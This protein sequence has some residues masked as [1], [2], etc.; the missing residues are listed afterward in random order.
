MLRMC[1]IAT[2]IAAFDIDQ[3]RKPATLQELVPKYL[4]RLDPCPVTGHPVE[5]R[6]GVLLS[7]EYEA[8]RRLTWTVRRR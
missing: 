3:G 1:R 7:P 8:G 2:A 5:Y 6:D 4:A